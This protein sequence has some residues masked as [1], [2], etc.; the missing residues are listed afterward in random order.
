VACRMFQI[1]DH[2]GREL[3][4]GLRHLS[5]RGAGSRAPGAADRPAPRGGASR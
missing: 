3:I 1:R 4:D 2:L 5:S